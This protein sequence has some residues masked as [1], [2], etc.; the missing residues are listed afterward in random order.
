MHL[1]VKVAYDGSSFHGSQRQGDDDQLSVEGSIAAALRKVCPDMEWSEWP[2]RFSSRTDAGVSALGNVFSLETGMDPDELLKALNANLNDIWCWGWGAPRPEQ[3]IRWASS[4]WYRY[5]L[6]P[7]T[8]RVD[9]MEELNR[10]LSLFEGEHDFS[11]LCR[12]EEEKNPV[13]VVESA[14]AFDL[15][16][17]GE[18]VIVDMVGSRFLWNQIR[19]MVGAALSVVKGEIDSVDLEVLLKEREGSGEALRGKVKP[20]PPTGLVLMD[21]KFKDIDFMVSRDALKLTIDR[22]AEKAWKASMSIL[23]HT[24]LRSMDQD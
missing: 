21:V 6:P 7:G 9:D 16:G 15:S 11:Y 2:L 12:L 19:R 22:H 10:V 18:L 4:R 24:A 5:H 13:T 23:L 20:L 1:A 8:I 17:R 3:N 14:K